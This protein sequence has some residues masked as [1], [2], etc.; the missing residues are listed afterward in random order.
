MTVSSVTASVSGGSGTVTLSI[1][2]A[3]LKKLAKVK[4]HKLS[5]KIT[6]TFTPT[7]GSAASKVKTLTLTQAALT[8]KKKATK[9]KKK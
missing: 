1:S 2:K 9:G 3:A 7:G 5:V 4:G 6:V 8:S